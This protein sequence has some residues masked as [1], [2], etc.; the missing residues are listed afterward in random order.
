MLVSSLNPRLVLFNFAWF[1][2]F[3]PNIFSRIVWRNKLF[4]HNS[5]QPPFYINIVMFSLTLTFSLTS[6][7]ELE[8][9]AS[10]QSPLQ[11]SVFGTSGQNFHKRSFLALS[12]FA[13]FP[14]LLP[15]ILSRIVVI[16]R[17]PRTIWQIFCSSLIS[18]CFFTRLK[19]RETSR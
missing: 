19:V 14:Y 17:S 7:N 1:R 2:Y 10:V 9:Q 16:A 6:Y 12:N 5:A 4:P 3:L 15:N 8:T 11:E 18:C 13:W